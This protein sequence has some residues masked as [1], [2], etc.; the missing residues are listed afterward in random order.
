MIV[1]QILLM[2]EV[3]GM[4]GN[5]D[6]GGVTEL[7]QLVKDLNIKKSLHL[8]SYATHLSKYLS[9]GKMNKT[10]ILKYFSDKTL[11]DSCYLHVQWQKPSK[12]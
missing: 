2:D 10:F 8:W 7:I 3:D 12:N 5:E 11:K 4:A 9:S 6:R 1:L